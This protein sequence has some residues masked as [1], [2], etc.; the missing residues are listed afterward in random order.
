MKVRE[1]IKALV[2]EPDMDSEVYLRFTDDNGDVQFNALD[3]IAD[4]QSSYYYIP[5]RVSTTCTTLLAE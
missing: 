2:D 3:G 5:G 4:E 1:L